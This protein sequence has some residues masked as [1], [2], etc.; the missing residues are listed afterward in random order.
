[1]VFLIS[2]SQVARI[3]GVSHQSLAISYYL[4]LGV[5]IGCLFWFFKLTFL[6]TSIGM[7]HIIKKKMESCQNSPMLM[8]RGTGLANAVIWGWGGS[9]HG[10]LHKVCLLIWA[11][12]R[13]QNGD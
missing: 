9:G 12:E 2:A 4:N 13:L 10:K 3:T 11:V 5:G 8:R 7:L 6:L 1:M